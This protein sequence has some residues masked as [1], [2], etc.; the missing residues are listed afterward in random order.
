MIAKE[1]IN[2]IAKYSDATAAAIS[3]QQQEEEMLL[4]VSD[5]G[6][7]FDKAKA[8]NGNGLGNIE[9]R[10]RQLDGNCSIDTMAGQGVKIHCRFPLA[11]I[12]HTG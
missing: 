12:S 10:C 11:I 7:G 9:Q 5:N 3:L 4:I 6:K 1:A 8:G 2:N